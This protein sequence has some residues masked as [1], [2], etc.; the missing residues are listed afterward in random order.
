[1][2]SL[3]SSQ[4]M[5]GGMLNESAASK[6]V[7]IATWLIKNHGTSI[8]YHMD[9]LLSYPG[10]LGRYVLLAVSARFY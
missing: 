9:T 8:M 10:A 6:K 5:N 7:V 2:S 1:M 3:S 4:L